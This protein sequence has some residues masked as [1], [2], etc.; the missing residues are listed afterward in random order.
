MDPPRLIGSGIAASAVGHLSVAAIILILAEMH[1][2]GAVTAEPIDGEQAIEAQRA[3][4]RTV[5]GH[6]RS[7]VAEHHRAKRAA[8]DAESP[9][10]LA[11]AGGSPRPLM[12]GV[13]LAL[14]IAGLEVQLDEFYVALLEF[15]RDL[16]LRQ[17][18]YHADNFAIRF[19][20]QELLPQRGEYRPLQIEVQSLL[21]A[22]QKLM[23]AKI[24]YIRQ[25]TLTP[26]EESLALL[27]PAGNWVELVESRPVR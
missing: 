13:V 3:I 1:P 2:F 14:T 5:L 20:V 27:D 10:Q 18:I 23:A 21:L 12:L 9:V 19:I 15:A 22:E 25:R 7:A 26:G 24:E 4:E 6:Q 17:L 8:Y 11:A 16:D